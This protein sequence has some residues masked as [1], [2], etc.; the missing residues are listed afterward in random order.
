M[1]DATAS[2][3]ISC[4]DDGAVIS[5]EVDVVQVNSVQPQPT[6]MPT[7]KKKKKKKSKSKTKSDAI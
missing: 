6:A 1:W 2:V 7:R 5:T 4:A 3:L